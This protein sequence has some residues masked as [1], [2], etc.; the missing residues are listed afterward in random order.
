MEAFE[1][2]YPQF[3]LEVFLKEKDL[4]W[5]TYSAADHTEIAIN[6]PSCE[7][8]GEP[9]PD[10]GHRLWLNLATGFFTCYRCSYCGSIPRLI[11][12]LSNVSF[13]EA[14]RIL[15]GHKLDPMDHLNL[16]LHDDGSFV[17]DEGELEL[18]ELELPYGYEPVDGPVD[19]LEERGIPWKYAARND[20]GTSDIGYVQNRLIVPYF[21]NT[22]LVFWQGRW[23]G[24]VKR[25]S[26]IQKVIN[27]KGVSARGILFNYDIAKQ[28][29]EIIICE[30]FIDAVKVGPDAVASNGK[31]IHPAQVEALQKTKAKRVVLM[32][33]EDA[34]TDEKWRRGKRKPSSIESAVTLLQT[35][36]EV[37]AVRMPDERDPGDYRF[38]SKA[39]RKLIKKAKTPRLKS[40]DSVST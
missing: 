39:I 3:D 16:K 33:D 8:Y 9:T 7:E 25:S 15:R 5:K 23:M 21:M 2:R 11:Q 27:P 12:K 34:W 30:G 4:E 37:K 24:D 31:R 6:C 36:F 29:E 10:T 14:L 26:A 28:Y 1:S 20:W 18:P 19:Y 35:C 32:W 17:V 22:R 13:T 38:Q 40:V